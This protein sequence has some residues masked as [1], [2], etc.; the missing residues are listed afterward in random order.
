M[1]FTLN[2]GQLTTKISTQIKLSQIT[3]SLWQR[4]YSSDTPATLL[5][6]KRIIKCSWS[7]SSWI[8]L[9][10]R[11]VNDDNEERYEV[12]APQALSGDYLT[13]SAV[14]MQFPK[15]TLTNTAAPVDYS[16]TVADGAGT[17]T[18]DLYYFVAPTGLPPLVPGTVYVGTEAALNQIGTDLAATIPTAPATLAPLITQVVQY[19]PRQQ[20]AWGPFAAQAAVKRIGLNIG[21]EDIQTMDKETIHMA[22]ETQTR[23]DIYKSVLTG[24]SL[25]AT[26]ATAAVGTDAPVT[27][28]GDVSDQELQKSFIL[29][30]YTSQAALTDRGYDGR[31]QTAFPLFMTCASYTNINVKWISDLR[32]LLMLYQES[33]IDMGDFP[34]V[35]VGTGT[36]L[37]AGAADPANAPIFTNGTTITYTGT[38][39]TLHTVVVPAAAFNGPVPVATAADGLA[40]NSVYG[41]T[42]TT[43]SIT[44]DT[45]AVQFGPGSYPTF[46]IIGVTTPLQS[47]SYNLVIRPRTDDPSNANGMA[48]ATLDYSTYIVGTGKLQL[49]DRRVRVKVALVTA[50]ERSALLR[51]CRALQWL[52]RIYERFDDKSITPGASETIYMQDLGTE[53]LHYWY[54]GVNETS[55]RQGVNFNYTNS[56][57]LTSELYNPTFPVW[58]YPGVSSISYHT[59]KVEGYTDYSS[60]SNF[61]QNVSN[62]GYFQRTSAFPGIQCTSFASWI[63]SVNPCGSV[64]GDLVLQEKVKTEPSELVSANTN[65]FGKPNTTQ[66]T[67]VAIVVSNSI[68]EFSPVVG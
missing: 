43:F 64:S 58:W 36:E 30:L 21:G 5:Y 41:T 1:S 12:S 10:S 67:L 7:A 6:A 60:N 39:G 38:D 40:P 48:P 65:F 8:T 37:G 61:T 19:T 56:T 66:Y 44:I 18:L 53:I 57:E 62:A 35:F 32:K 15:V 13:M 2:S 17:T 24:S 51:D 47:G 54:A 22:L 33:L 52:F 29:P 50:S 9:S 42:L 14:D 49:S 63:N 55:K 45:V 59:S 3:R 4:L 23:E 27:L 46:S 25:P 34:I 11:L 16:V 31:Y 20:V 26:V 28:L 68:V